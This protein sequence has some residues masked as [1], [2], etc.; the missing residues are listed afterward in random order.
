MVMKMSCKMNE[1]KDDEEKERIKNIQQILTIKMFS[2][3][4][5]HQL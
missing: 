2:P 1:I 5:D 3:L 4:S